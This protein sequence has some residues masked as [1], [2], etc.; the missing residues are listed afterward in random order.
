MSRFNVLPESTAA[1]RPGQLRQLARQDAILKAALHLFAERGYFGT[2]VPDVAQLA[3]VGTGTIYRYFENKEAL[4]NAVLMHSIDQM[5]MS[6]V[7][8][9]G[10]DFTKP[11][12]E[13]FR[14]FWWRLVRFVREYPDEFRFLEL[15]YHVPYRS[16]ES[17]ER[18]RAGM[19]PIWFFVHLAKQAG[20]ARDQSVEMTVA[21][22]WGL[23]IGL[24][25]AGY[26]GY[27]DINQEAF[28]LAEQNA[29]S[30]FSNGHDGMLYV[31]SYKQPDQPPMSPLTVL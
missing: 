11:V 5:W 27:I 7:E 8:N 1:M 19:A 22:V 24:H 30:V 20:V 23:F 13:I 10:F 26:S 18:E 2:A 31:S 6:V 15:Q 25:K 21:L 29:W 14:E 4:V 28:E 16:P 3:N 9:E 17:F 12:R